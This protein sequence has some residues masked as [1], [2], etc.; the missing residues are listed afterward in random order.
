[1]IIDNALEK[2]EKANPIFKDV[3]PKIYSKSEIDPIKLG[4]L[5]DLFTNNFNFE[6]NDESG[7]ALGEI[8]QFFMGEFSRELGEKGGEFYTPPC[9][10]KL[11]VAILN[12]TKGRVYDPCCGSGGM[13]VY[14]NEFVKAHS[15]NTNNISIYGQE[16]NANT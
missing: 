1:M 6:E 5:V 16:L 12:P 3:L 4:A 7:D 13:F 8:Y 14:S 2:F 15:G 9:I 10:V 11:L